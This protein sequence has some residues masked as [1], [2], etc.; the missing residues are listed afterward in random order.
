MRQRRMSLQLRVFPWRP[1]R[2]QFLKEYAITDSKN[3]IP[4]P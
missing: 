4:S 1:L 3:K 2:L